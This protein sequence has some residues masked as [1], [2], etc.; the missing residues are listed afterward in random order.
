[1]SEI[2]RRHRNWLVAGLVASLAVNAFF[3]G[4]AA[5]DLLGARGRH[6]DGAQPLRYELRWLKGKLP[7]EFRR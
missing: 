4:A 2:T 7:E 5:T 3:I 1:M 6:K